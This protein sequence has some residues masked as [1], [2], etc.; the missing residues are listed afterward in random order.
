MMP[1]LF[2]A[3]QAAA[4]AVRAEVHRVAGREPALEFVLAFLAR[5]GLADAP[6]CR[7]LWH[8]CPFAAAL[9][10]RPPAAGLGYEVTRARAAEVKFGLSQM[11]WALAD[12]GTLVQDATA[13]GARLVSTLPPI[14]IA[15][16]PTGRI[17]PDLPALLQRTNLAACGYAAL[18]TGPSRTADIERVLTIGVHGPRRLVI[19]CIDAWDGG[20]A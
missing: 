17:L 15:L 2:P 18:I 20:A 6:G 7:A 14:H 1:E 13:P 8:D 19:V 12:T 9:R 3:F 11:D 4:T 5:E 16:L 10:A